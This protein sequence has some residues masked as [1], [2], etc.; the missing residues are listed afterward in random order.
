MA[1]AALNGY[2]DGGLL[3][4]WLVAAAG[5][6]PFALTFALTDAPIGRQPT[7]AN[8]AS[9]L[10]G[11]AGLYGV[12]VGTASYLLGVGARRVG[13]RRDRKRPSSG[14]FEAEVYTR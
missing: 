8:A 7:A 11:S 1:A 13:E 6:L 3:V 5:P 4:S 10:L 2:A 12:A 9:T 14:T